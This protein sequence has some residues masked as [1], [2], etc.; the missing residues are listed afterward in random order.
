MRQ[1]AHNNQNIT[2]GGQTMEQTQT[3]PPWGEQ[4]SKHD[5]SDVVAY[6]P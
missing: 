5:I 2:Y 4:L 1:A 6:S 3:M